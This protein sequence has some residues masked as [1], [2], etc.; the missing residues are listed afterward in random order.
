MSSSIFNSDDSVRTIPKHN[1]LKLLVWNIVFLFIFLASWELYL[2]SLGH[3]PSISDSL[4]FWAEQREKIENNLETT[5]LVGSSRLLHGLNIYEWERLSGIRPIQLSS[6]GTTPKYY[7][8]DIANNTNFKGTMIIDMPI[9]LFFTDIP[10]IEA[11]AIKTLNFYNSNTPARKASH[12]IMKFLENYFVFIEPKRF[13]LSF[14]LNR[15][16]MTNREG[17]FRSIPTPIFTLLD[18]NRQAY[19]SNELLTDIEFQQD[20]IDYYEQFASKILNPNFRDYKNFMRNFEQTLKGLKSSIEKIKNRGGKVIIL[21]LPSS[22][23]FLSIEKE[24]F[25]RANFWNRVIEE[26][27]EDIAINFEDYPE[28]SSFELPDDS[29]LNNKDAIKFTQNLIKIIKKQKP[30]LIDFPHQ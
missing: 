1:W 24:Y 13:D 15:I 28:L 6:S 26:L 20:T 16:E 21:N 18:H 27:N 10:E 25:P 22:G 30:S 4:D 17:V 2:R 14:I 5:L 3:K 23:D 11:K 7:I 8:E 19:M 9:S 29:H 12:Y